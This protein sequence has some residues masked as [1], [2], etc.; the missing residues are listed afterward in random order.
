LNS[1]GPRG[2]ARGE[3][4]SL[5]TEGERG[6]RI[7]FYSRAR[8]TGTTGGR[9]KK[10]RHKSFLLGG[11]RREVMISRKTG[12]GMFPEQRRNIFLN[13]QVGEKTLNDDLPNPRRKRNPCLSSENTRTLSLRQCA[14]WRVKK[15][16]RC[17]N[18]HGKEE[19]GKETRSERLA[20][21]VPGK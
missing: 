7:H 8:V 3:H 9:R 17:S 2:G 19:K 13:F 14:S 15:E 4:V 6:E 16:S 11:K 10:L 20:L 12:K 18:H 1:V 5:S 21:L